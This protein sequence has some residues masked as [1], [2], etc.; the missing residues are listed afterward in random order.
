MGL[1]PMTST[2]V[3]RSNQLSYMLLIIVLAKSAN[4]NILT[5]KYRFPPFF[6]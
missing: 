4:S 1:G 2:G 5:I 3:L 6:W